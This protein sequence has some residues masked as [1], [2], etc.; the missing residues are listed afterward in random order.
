MKVVCLGDSNTYGYDARLLIDNRYP[1]EHRW[2]DILASMTGWDI[3]NQGLNGREIP[4]EGIFVPG[5]TDLFVIM[6]GTN[7]IL[8][9]NSVDAVVSRM[10]HFLSKLAF[11]RNKTL[12]ISPPPMEMGAWVLE[13][14]IV[15]R[16]RELSGRYQALAQEMGVSFVD[17]G[18]W[19]VAL[20]YDGIHFTE[21]GQTV[22]ANGLLHHIKKGRL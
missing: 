18:A 13:Q 20:S 4:R 5:D 16:S 7:D 9:G 22:F 8:Q 3:V 10:N 11:P 21:E 14:S 6:L 15:D 12:L 19:G 1:P 2:V 17:A